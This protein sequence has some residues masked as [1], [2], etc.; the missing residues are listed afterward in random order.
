MQQLRNIPAT[1]L[2]IER[3]FVNNMLSHDRDSIIVRKTLEI[4]SE[5]GMRV[6]A[7]GV[8]TEEQLEYL[9][10]HGCKIVQGYHFS[11]PLPCAEMVSWLGQYRSMQAV[12]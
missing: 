12:N 6:V 5:L 4:G 10:L 8:E 1:E 3:S 11:R 7:E 9:R 2:K